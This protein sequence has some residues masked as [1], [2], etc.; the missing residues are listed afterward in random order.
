MPVP[1]ISGH[2]LPSSAIS[3]T[4]V[5]DGAARKIEFSLSLKRVDDSLAAIYGD[6]KTQADNLVT[7]AGNWIGGLSG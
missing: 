4:V 1:S 6:L 5:S 2:A 3:S 7:S